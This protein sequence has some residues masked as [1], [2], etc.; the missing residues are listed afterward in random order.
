MRWTDD[1]SQVFYENYKTYFARP[2]LCNGCSMDDLV[3]I[4]N[5]TG[6]VSL[7]SPP[8]GTVFRERR[9]TSGTRYI[10]SRTLGKSSS[11]GV[12]SSS[13]SIHSCRFA[14]TM[15]TISSGPNQ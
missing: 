8:P 5:P 1:G 7:S 11:R 15:S 12:S 4:P 6:L 14:Y 13:A 10:M 2:D 9:Q 3:T